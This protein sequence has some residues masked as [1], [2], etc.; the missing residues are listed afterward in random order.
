MAT[1][2]IVGR[3]NVGK[4]TVFNRLLGMKLSIVHKEPGVTRDRVYGDVDWCGK[5]LNIIDTGGFF[6]DEE[7]SLAR[8]ISHQIELALREAD[9]IYF[10]VDAKTGL[11]ATDEEIG[12]E[13]RKT[14]KPIFL[15]INK[16][17]N[18]RDEAKALE[19]SRLGF[20]K[21]FSIS[22]EGGIGLGEVLDE[23][24]KITQTQKLTQTG[25]TIKILI[26][27]RP[28]A[29]KSTLL[30]SIIKQERAI[31][32]EKPGTTRDLINA[33]FSFNQKQLEIIDTG[34]IRRRSRIKEPIEFYSMMR[35]L[36][37]IDNVDLIILIFD[38]SQGVVKEDC[39]IASMVLAKAKNLVI[40][41]NKMDLIGK[42]NRRKV[43]TATRVS[44]EF[45]NFAPLVLISAKINSGIEELLNAILNVQ[46][47]SS[48]AVNID[49]LDNLTQGLKPPPGGMVL[50][51]T[52]IGRKPPVFIVMT[53]VRVRE[54]YVRYIRNSIRN[55]FGFQGVPILIRT[56]T[57]R[58]QR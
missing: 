19:F 52:Q 4:S 54:S 10:V 1:V 55:Y 6:P 5:T 46:E 40:A 33:R 24:I 39:R 41:A 42:K 27:G 2:A 53:T 15:L 30:N 16:V 45:V 35:A 13:L 43:I 25:K 58:G 29:G 7:I 44:L 3:K 47:E 14:N 57:K 31:V 26:L 12:S 22:A 18:R 20:T 11:T 21:L 38:V 36:R 48:K 50:K 37:N 23:T 49:V 32:D 17:D 28:N 9:L 34:G 56:K 51:I 8:K